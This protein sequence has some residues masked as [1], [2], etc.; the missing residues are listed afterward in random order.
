MSRKEAAQTTRERL[1][2]A[3]ETLF[4]ARGYSATSLEAIA[5]EAGYTKGAVYANF[6]GKEPLFLEV[7]DRIGK[8]DLDRLVSDIASTPDRTRIE[9]LLIDWAGA[10]AESGSWPLALIEFVRQKK[11]DDVVIAR[12]TDILHRNWRTLGEAVAEPLGL[13][14]SALVVGAALHEI[15]YAPAMTLVSDPSARDLMRL[16]LDRPR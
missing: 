3:A 2:V 14:G 1:L 15:A 13:D 12:L 6:S 8:R 10:R 9:T 11:D 7:L 16:F 5:L 4:A